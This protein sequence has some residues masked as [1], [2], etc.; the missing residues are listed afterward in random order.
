MFSAPWRACFAVLLVLVGLTLTPA[1]QACNEDCKRAQAEAKNNTKYPSYLNLKY[2]QSTTQDFLLSARQS[3]QRY[4]DKQ[5]P[6]AH[7]GGARNIRQYI[8]QRRDWLQECETYMHALDAGN[9]F[10]QA[11]TTQQ[12]FTAMNKVADELHNIMQRKENKAE[13]KE[14]VI[15]PAAEAFDRLFTQVDSHIQDLQLRGLL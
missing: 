2:C 13:V 6:T 4:R 7:R 11:T 14:L 10:R 9:V 1:S 15:A 12:I 3:L 5:L 8:L